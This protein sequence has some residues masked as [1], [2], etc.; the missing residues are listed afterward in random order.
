MYLAMCLEN[1]FMKHIDT[2]VFLRYTTD[3]DILYKVGILCTERK[4]AIMIEGV[5]K[6]DFPVFPCIRI[7]TCIY[8]G[9]TRDFLTRHGCIVDEIGEE[10]MR[11]TLPYGTIRKETLRYH[12]VLIYRVVLPDGAS[13]R[14]WH[15]IK[16]ERSLLMN[17]AHGEEQA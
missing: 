2:S 15:N 6:G 13:F 11:V 1:I 3:V 9:P 5:T 12:A 4:G 8:T 16:R 14:E 7:T 17:M 10:T